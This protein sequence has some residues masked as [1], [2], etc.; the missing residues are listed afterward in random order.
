MIKVCLVIITI[1]VLFLTAYTT[2]APMRK[3]TYDITNSISEYRTH[4][5]VKAEKR[6]TKRM[7][8]WFTEMGCVEGSYYERMRC[9]TDKLS[10]EVEKM[11][12]DELDSPI[13]S[14]M[15]RKEYRN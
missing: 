13:F 11:F 12:N 8:E 15:P 6:E 9:S 2:Y 14:N 5:R 4:L 3:V 10:E 7:L 1:S